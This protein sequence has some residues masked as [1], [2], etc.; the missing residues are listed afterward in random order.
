MTSRNIVQ[1]SSMIVVNYHILVDL[2]GVME[3]WSLLE[4]DDYWSWKLSLKRFS[5]FALHVVTS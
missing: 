3:G 5:Q 4:G 1:I 2:F